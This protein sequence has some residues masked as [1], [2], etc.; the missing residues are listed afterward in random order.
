MVSNSHCTKC[1]KSLGVDSRMEIY[2]FL[3]NKKVSTVGDIVDKVGLTQPTVSYHLKEMKKN[4]ILSSSKK[5]KEVFYSVS[6]LC[7]H[8]NAACVLKNLEFPAE[9]SAAIQDDNKYEYIRN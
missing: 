4:G 1:F 3:A 2:T 9:P 5:G 7:P 6:K 8:F